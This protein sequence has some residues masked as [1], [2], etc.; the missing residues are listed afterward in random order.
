MRL[1]L[2][3]PNTSAATT[4]AMVAIAQ[5]V[6]PAD[7][8]IFGMTA[9]WG[10][11]LITNPEALAVATEAVIAMSDQIHDVDGVIV[12]AFGDPGL[13]ALRARLS[14][15]VTGIAEAGMAEA[16]SGRRRFA[17]VT[18]TPDL[19]DAIAAKAAREGHS[20]FAGTWVTPGEPTSLMADPEQLENALYAACVTAIEEGAAEA[21]VIGG[22]PLAVA[23]KSLV[24]R[25]PVPII[26]P[27]PAA[28]RLAYVRAFEGTVK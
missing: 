20:N 16:A 6:V 25:L 14:V 10:I 17:V 1:A 19:A 12:S 9:P 28:T 24:S 2:I 3:N 13:E 22:G 15:P 23:A 7:V 21:I 5:S 11:P 18:T 26:E 27:V 8:A 4:E